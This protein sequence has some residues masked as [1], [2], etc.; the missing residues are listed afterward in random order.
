MTVLAEPTQ[1]PTETESDPT[2]ALEIID[3]RIR[4]WKIKLVDTIADN[5]SSG[6]VVLGS[7]AVPLAQVDVRLVGGV[8]H[9]NG[10]L[11]GSGAGGAVLG[12]PLNA[13]VWLANTL[14]PRGVVLE[15]GH[16]VLPGSITAAVPAAHIDI[17]WVQR[18]LRRLRSD[19]GVRGHWNALSSSFGSAIEFVGDPAGGSDGRLRTDGI[20]SL[21]LR[22]KGIRSNDRRRTGS[23][24]VP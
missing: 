9:R 19:D 24:S 13:L 23:T 15:A 14:G 7:T 4:D 21:L 8:L 12:S 11:V 20:D 5:A 6:A 16:V 3:S 22:L 17:I 10:E 1:L 18:P 2:P